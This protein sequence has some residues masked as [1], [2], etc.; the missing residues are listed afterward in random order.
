MK[1]AY[2]LES[3]E[4]YGG[5]K[6][7]LMQA[8]ALARRGH[9]VTVVSPQT[10]PSWFPL[11]QARFEHSPF[12]ASQAL[13]EADVRVA[14]F[15]RT[16]PDALAGAH[17]PVFHLCQGYEGGFPFYADARHEIE[18]VYRL[19]ARKLAVSATL[20]ER[21]EALGFGPAVDIG[22]A[23]DPGAFSPGPEKPIQNP[24]VVLVVG[25]IEID[26]K[27]VDVALG[28]LQIFRRRGGA[29]RLRRVSYF[30]ISEAERRMGLTDEYHHRLA[31]ERMPFAYR[32][33]DVF[34]GASRA[35]EGFGLPTLEALACGV[36]ALLSDVPSQREIANGAAW[37][38]RDG[39]PE[40]LAS[41]LPELFTEGARRRARTE[42]PAAA[43][44]FSTA[45]VAERLEAAFLEGLGTVL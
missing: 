37:H 11:M 32:S 12:A 14:T 39:D 29:F 40:S 36:P 7:V 34:I 21:L 16:V 19:P 26:S 8:E 44:R 2:L 45:R 10:G 35:E 15:W 43:A 20:A 3:A 27:G 41:A 22:Q 31:P 9:R 18:K 28:G 4:P 13:R 1:I 24:P 5:V 30:P 42:G 33:S 25:P 17:G 23:F 38:F 6:I